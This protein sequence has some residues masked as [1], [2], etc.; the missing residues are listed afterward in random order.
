[1]QDFIPP[2]GLWEPNSGR[3]TQCPGPA[4]AETSHRSQMLTLKREN[5]SIFQIRKG[6]ENS[7]TVFYVANLFT[8]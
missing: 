3:H 2:C 8:V 6:I 7:V 5:H 4:L 1:M